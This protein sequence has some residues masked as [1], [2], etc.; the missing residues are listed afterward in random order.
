M[1]EES[2]TTRGPA[3]IMTLPTN[4][5][6]NNQPYLPRPSPKAVSQSFTSVAPAYHKQQPTSSD[7]IANNLQQIL[8]SLSSE[9]QPPGSNPSTMS[10]PHQAYGKDQQQAKAP[11]AYEPVSFSAAQP[12]T[13][14]SNQIAQTLPSYR[15]NYYHPGAAAPVSNKAAV[16]YGT[17][18][19]QSANK[20]P[21]SAMTAL[22][23]AQSQGTLRHETPAAVQ[24]MKRP[25]LGQASPT[26][27]MSSNR[28]PAL[29]NQNP[30]QT[31]SRLNPPA[32]VQQ[33]NAAGIQQVPIRNFQGYNYFP[34][35]AGSMVNN[36]LGFPERTSSYAQIHNP[37]VWH[38][39]LPK[40]KTGVPVRFRIP[41]TSLSI[42]SMG[43]LRAGK[44][45]NV[46]QTGPPLKGIAQNMPKTPVASFQQPFVQKQQVKLIQPMLNQNPEPGGPRAQVASPLQQN[47][48]SLSSKLAL[49]E[50]P[51]RQTITSQMSQTHFP[52]T[53]APNQRPSLP[54][55]AYNNNMFARPPYSPSVR[56]KVLLSS[57]RIHPSLNGALA[58]TTQHL[59]QVAPLRP[60]YIYGQNSWPWGAWRNQAPPLKLASS[61]SSSPQWYPT[62]NSPFTV[63]PQV[64]LY[65]Y[66]YPKTIMNPLNK[67]GNLRGEKGNFW[68]KLKDQISRTVP[69]R[70]LKVATVASDPTVTGQ[71]QVKPTNLQ[72]GQSKS[73]IATYGAFRPRVQTSKN[74]P[75]YGVVKEPLKTLLS[76]GLASSSLHNPLQA[77]QQVQ[78]AL[79]QTPL[80]KGMRQTTY[81]PQQTRWT[82]PGVANQLGALTQPQATVNT[83]LPGDRKSQLMNRLR[84]RPIYIQTVPYQTYYLLQQQPAYN[85]QSDTQRY[86]SKVL[87]DILR[88]RY[89]TQKK[90][91]KRRGAEQ[92]K[93]AS[94]KTGVNDKRTAAPKRIIHPR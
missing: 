25:L 76:G 7:F 27:Q 32:K 94:D 83:Q 90:K 45:F 70:N 88:L 74:A 48:Q 22:L 85:T 15:W 47:Q 34:T 43:Q 73:N 29:L 12:Q 93:S 35:S 59:P 89:L 80:V 92:R 20:N 3:S 49:L 37:I 13:I 4:G 8:A 66:L 24:Q 44:Q 31:S 91:K 77:K 82:L 60:H 55:Q 9:N 63:S 75:Y 5:Q 14:N 18:A 39:P 28:Q 87:G 40:T 54:I 36:H 81:L 10:R 58:Q 1:T 50:A 57:N 26:R 71:I 19:M 16:R 30:Y 33:G 17:Q 69:F 61:R 64:L 68:Q 21:P 46:H 86:L 78:T 42:N 23:P 79:S 65:Y 62:T 41:L 53:A 51:H 38:I 2:S 11:N 84:N 56:Q 67:L 6:R 52:Q 72:T